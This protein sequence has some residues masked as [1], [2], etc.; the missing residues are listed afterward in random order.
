MHT[1]WNIAVDEMF[2]VVIVVV[3]RF[4]FT[5]FRAET[6]RAPTLRASTLR[7]VDAAC[8]P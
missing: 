2:E 4:T 8:P 7:S 5:V 6:L 1:G 3:A